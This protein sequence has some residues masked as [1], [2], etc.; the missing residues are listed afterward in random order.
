MHLP[1][2]KTICLC[3]HLLYT[4]HDEY[5]KAGVAVRDGEGNL[6]E[7]PIDAIKCALDDL[8]RYDACVSFLH[9]S[10]P[11]TEDE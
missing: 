1:D 8:I 2:R 6:L 9:S 4:K 11:S 3:I 7:S 10:L 5:I